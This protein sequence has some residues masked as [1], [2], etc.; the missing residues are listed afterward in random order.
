M[1]PKADDAEAVEVTEVARGR[2]T[3]TT[4]AKATTTESPSAKAATA[5]MAKVQSH[6]V[7]ADD[8]RAFKPKTEQEWLDALGAEAYRVMRQNGTERPFSSP[9]HQTGHQG[10]FLCKGCG[11][12]L[13]D[14]SAQFDSGCG[15]PSFDREASTGAM[16]EVLDKSHGMVRVEVRCATCDGHLGH[17]F[18]D[19]PTAT[20]MRYCINGVCL[21]PQ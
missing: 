17:L 14:A 1:I 12:K 5:T 10:E 8:E 13:F 16:K 6:P 3:A 21:I 11:T 2:A 4:K 15:W 18:P 9:L 20:G 7:M 19:G